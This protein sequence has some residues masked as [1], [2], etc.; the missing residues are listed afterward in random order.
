MMKFTHIR[1]IYLGATP[2]TPHTFTL[3]ISDHEMAFLLGFIMMYGLFRSRFVNAVGNI[4]GELL[5]LGF[6]LY[7][8]CTLLYVYFDDVNYKINK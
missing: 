3:V 1:S 5:R 6:C 8:Y 4:I 2:L 7:C